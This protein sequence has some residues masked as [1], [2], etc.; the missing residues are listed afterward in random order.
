MLKNPEIYKKIKH[1]LSNDEELPPQEP[2]KSV[3]EPPIVSV[4]T[5]QQHTPN[6]QSKNC[7]L[8]KL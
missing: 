7:Y 5:S 1:Q 4:S 8:Y 2:I 6:F 3:P